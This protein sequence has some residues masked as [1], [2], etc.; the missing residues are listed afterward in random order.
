MPCAQPKVLGRPSRRP[1]RFRSLVM[2]GTHEID[3]GR[4]PTRLVV[5]FSGRTMLSNRMR[6]SMVRPKLPDSAKTKKE[7]AG[8]S[9]A[10]YPS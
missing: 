10:P 7:S 5:Q 1:V 9:R 2:F 8:S 6:S 3:A 4:A